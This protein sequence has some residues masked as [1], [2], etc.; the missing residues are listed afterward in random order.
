MKCPKCSYLGFET[1]ER[2]KH[3]GYDFSLLVEPPSTG[4]AELTLRETA[5]QDGAVDAYWERLDPEPPAGSPG[6]FADLALHGENRRLGEVAHG[7]AA[8]EESSADGQTPASAPALPL[9]APDG[10]DDAPLVRLPAAPRAPVAVRKT[11]EI[12]RLRP[13]SKAAGPRPPAAV[14]TPVFE[15]A[16]EAEPAAAEGASM[17]P[18]EVARVRERSEAVGARDGLP[19]GAVGARVLAAAI[20][21]GILAGIDLA[22]VYFTLRMAELAMSQWR[23]LPLP[24][25]LVFLLFVKVAY[26]SAF[27]SIGGQTIGKM[28]AKIKVV[29][30][31][32]GTLGVARAMRRS[33][34]VLLSIVPLGVGLLPA[35]FGAERRAFHDRIA[36]TR[37]VAAPSA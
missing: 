1:G 27:T 14:H 30:D 21:H 26:F 35:L 36:G 12:P 5:R 31:D 16:H 18:M 10:D 23:V 34:A 7:A 9:F 4:A 32:A 28:A 13:P 20:D 22:V 15:F 2:C 8:E 29:A 25:L 24:P 19:A 11:P 17:A 6:P 37:V 33:V 3:C